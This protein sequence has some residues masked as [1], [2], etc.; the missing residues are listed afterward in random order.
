MR[1]IVITALLL[2][3]FNASAQWGHKPPPPNPPPPVPLD[4][5]LIALIGAGAALG[6][7]KYKDR[8][9]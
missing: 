2:L 7:K 5:G 6:Y 4:G 8:Q 9:E 3:S 1:T